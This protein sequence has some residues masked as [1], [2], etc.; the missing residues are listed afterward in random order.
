MESVEESPIVEAV[1]EVPDGPQAVPATAPD[2]TYPSIWQSFGIMLI[3]LLCMVAM[4]PIMFAVG[5]LDA[6]VT[7]LLFYVA[8]GSLAFAIVHFTRKRKTG[9]T[10]YRFRIDSWKLVLPLIVASIALL[11]GVIGPLISLIPMPPEVN[12]NF[13]EMMGQPSLATFLALVIAAPILEELLFRGI[14]LDGLLKRYR[15]LTAILVSSIIFGL[16]HLNPWQFITAFVIG[17]FA[18]WVYFRTGSVGPCILIHA[19]I[20][21][22]AYS[23]GLISSTADVSDQVT[24]SQSSPGAVLVFSSVCVMAICLS[25]LSLRRE[26]NRLVLAKAVE[27][28]ALPLGITEQE[29]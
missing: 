1:L 11:F 14:M 28:D 19:T 9:H 4:V 18:G 22:C 16:A 24:P 20:N 23:I 2:P 26:F 8:A 15:P 10:T 27:Q 13:S 6:D 21:F 17:C 12:E 5:P 7:L 29:I 3:F 25:V